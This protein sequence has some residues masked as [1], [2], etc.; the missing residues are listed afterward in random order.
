LG[1]LQ[2][3]GNRF[4]VQDYAKRDT[5]RGAEVKLSAQPQVQMI[6]R[7]IAPAAQMMLLCRP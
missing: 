6:G 3:F 7:M 1:R 5:R 4:N 2:G